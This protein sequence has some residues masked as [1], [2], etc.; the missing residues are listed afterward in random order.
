MSSIV[1]S[2]ALDEKSAAI[3]QSLPNFSHFVR[4]C[5]FRHAASLH[6]E[7]NREKEWAG[8]KRCNP[9]T[10]P[11]CWSCWPNGSPPLKAIKQFRQD[12]LSVNFLD[13]KAREHNSRL[14][15]LVA[16]EKK[17]PKV[18]SDPPQKPSLWQKLR[19]KLK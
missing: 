8:T 10:Q 6:A 4:E 13:Q 5:L 9:S 18:R 16:M 1:K 15:D 14:I 17:V 12:G 2:V 19:Q 11:T 7:C 3:A